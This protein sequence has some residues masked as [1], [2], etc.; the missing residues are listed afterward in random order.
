MKKSLS[1]FVGLL[2]ALGAVSADAATNWGTRAG[3]SADLSSAPATRTREKI[4][5]EKYQ[6]R[7]L[8]KTYESKDAGDL[9][10]TKPQNRSALYKQYEGANSSSARATKTTQR[11][12]RSEKIVNKMRRKYF[13]AHPFYQPLG[14]MFGSHTD[15]SY[16][17]SSYDFKINQ[18]LPVWNEKAN[19][20]QV[21]LNGLG[22]KW[23]MTGFSIK[24]DFSYGITDRIAILAMA[25][26]D[27]N[28]YKFE[29]D[30]NSPD[31]K[32]DDD[33]LN[34][35]GI[36]GQWRFVDTNEWIAT[37]SAHFQHQKDVANNFLVELK[38][39]YK[40]SSSTIYGLVRGWYVDL[41]G[42]SYGNGVEGTDE[43]GNMVMTYIPYQVG[44]SS[45]MYVEGGLGVFSVLNEDWTLNVE[46]IFGDYDWHNQGNIKG[47][48]G[49]Q[50]NDWF[51]LNLYAKVAFYDSA[52][53]KDLD[54][55]WMENGITAQAPDGTEFNL[56]SLTKIGTVELDNYAETKIGL[57]V[58]FQ[59]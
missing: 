56:D 34:L 59:F 27:I 37:A 26:Y 13:L 9:Y 58:M 33:G 10:Y 21:V 8:T 51:A 25:Q 20:Y 32:M 24:E 53:G 40:V 5:Y 23:D 46:A 49:W 29:W 52:D 7:T 47:A 12:T 50:P 57:Q 6:T 4:N 55:Y 31:D 42:N 48:I 14:G 15:L 39:G 44:D 17:S 3:S 18:T 22:A 45:V 38:G 1:V 28:E 54:L 36:G 11:T 35:F 2:V 43:N 16:N 30:D 41:D 19:E